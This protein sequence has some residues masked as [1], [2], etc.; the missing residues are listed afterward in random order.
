[1]TPT[2]G[3]ST[4]KLFGEAHARIGRPPAGR[5]VDF[6]LNLSWCRG[7]VGVI[8]NAV[9]DLDGGGGLVAIGCDFGDGRR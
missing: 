1:M 9:K 7:Q 4:E 3:R 5:A 6:W 2:T 8:L